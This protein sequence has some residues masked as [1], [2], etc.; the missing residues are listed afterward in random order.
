MTDN[1]QL[2]WPSFQNH[3]NGLLTKLHLSGVFSDVTLVCDDQTEFKAHRFL[4]SACSTVFNSI[5]NN[6]DDSSFIY[7]SGVER[8]ELESILQFMYLGETTFDEDQVNEFLNV[9]RDLEV[10]GISKKVEESDNILSV[11]LSNK[12]NEQAMTDMKTFMIGEVTYQ[13]EECTSSFTSQGGLLQHKN[14]IHELI[15]YPCIQCDYQATQKVNLKNHVRS[16]HEK[17]RYP[18]MHCE[19]VASEPTHLKKH[20]NKK[21]IGIKYP[22]GKCTFITNDT[23]KLKNHVTEEHEGVKRYQCTYCDSNLKHRKS[24]YAHMREKHIIQFK[25]ENKRNDL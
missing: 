3:T 23:T 2:T 9:A 5:L 10:K 22:C 1:I 19:H 16:I 25:P 11:E 20:M 8:D 24:L 15:K 6:T 17:R 18:C 4:L 21:H 14:S 7:L 13:C 12:D